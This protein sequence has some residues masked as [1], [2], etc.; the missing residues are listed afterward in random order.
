MFKPCLNPTVASPTAS[1]G[2]PGPRGW[3]LHHYPPPL[4][5]PWLASTAQIAMKSL[6][7]ILSLKL[8]YPH[9]QITSSLHPSLLLINLQVYPVFS[10]LHI[11]GPLT[12]LTHSFC[13]APAL[14]YSCVLHQDH[15]F[16]CSSQ[17]NSCMKQ[18]G[19]DTKPRLLL[20]QKPP[21]IRGKMRALGSHVSIKVGKK[22]MGGSR[23]SPW[24]R[25]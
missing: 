7:I 23:T 2:Q 14:I 10:S 16:N 5:S 17:D 25:Q 8:R 9:L 21:E 24:H 3:N 13:A 22:G 6:P 18:L 12:L 20:P 4:K 11:H 15:L 1:A 19:C